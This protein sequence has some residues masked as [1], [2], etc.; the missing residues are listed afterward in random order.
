MVHPVSDRRLHL[1]LAVDPGSDPITGTVASPDGGEA[2][3]VGWVELAALLDELLERT[4]GDCAPPVSRRG[5]AAA[6]PRPR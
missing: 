5:P 1:T 3:F 6:S 2:S 4:D